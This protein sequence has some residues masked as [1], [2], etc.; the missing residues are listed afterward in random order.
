M[1]ETIC[2]KILEC[3]K[4][5]G[6]DEADVLGINGTSTSIEVRKQTLE[7]IERSES[8]EIGLR[9][10]I[11]KRQAVVS[12]SDLSDPSIKFMAERAV[13][14]AK[15]AP[16]DPYCGLADK[17]QLAICGN[18]NKFELSDERDEPDPDELEDI[19][20]ETENFALQNTSLDQV[21]A[22]SAGYSKTA[23]HLCASNGFNGGYSK[24]SF[25]NSCVAIAR[26]QSG[27]E[28]DYD[29]DTRIFKSDLRS[30]EEIGLLAAE[31]AVA[32]L[33]ARKPKTGV[34]PVLFDERISS[35]LIGHLLSATNG[36]AIAR[37]SSWLLHSRGSMVLPEN[38]SIIEDPH[39]QRVSGSR[40]FDVE[41]IETKIRK[42][43]DNGI[44]CDWTTDL[45]SSR[46]LNLQST[47]NAARGTG[48]IP[49]PINWNIS[50]T[51]GAQSKA[52]LLKDMNCG[53]LVTSMIGS[54]INP[55]T[56][57]YSRGASGFW[58]ENGEVQY[59]ISELTIA[60]N[61]NQMLTKMI[62]ANDA[63]QYVSRVVPSL[64][65]DG[66]TIAG[67]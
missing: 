13:D 59:P 4:L 24:T 1:L 27:L 7:Q 48:G 64:L 67:S 55:N 38:L 44:L 54:T 43:V 12:G 66:M 53:V 28:R 32:R 46:K 5:A 57:D 58:V 42:I 22:A 50:L 23:I 31:R 14:M 61:L 3:A 65:I 40:P 9:V 18:I 11:G 60:G 62:P 19:A 45:S 37:G 63:R 36:A 34:Y 21:E 33:E 41:G 8:T 56:G 30:P 35:S 6:A 29:G 51:Q 20:K 39:R 25:S 15:A 16:I 2:Q 10:F 49:T 17:S 26:S 52:E 47:G